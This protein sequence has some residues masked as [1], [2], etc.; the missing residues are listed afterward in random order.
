MGE[1]LGTLWQIVRVLLI[2]FNFLFFVL[3]LAFIGLGGYALDNYGAVFAFESGQAWSSAPSLLIALGVFIFLVSFLG[4]LGACLKHRV[5]LFVFGV[6][7]CFLLVLT[8]TG[9]ILGFQFKSKIESQLGDAMWK[10]IR[11]YNNTSGDKKAWDDL[12]EHWPKC[13]GVYH[14]F[15][16]TNMSLPIP[17]SC[18]IDGNPANPIQKQGCYNKTIGAITGHVAEAAGIATFVLFTELFGVVMAFGLG[19]QITKMSSGNYE[20][21]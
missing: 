9:T 13:C 19:R 10:S 18:H 16:W 17:D 7:M 21:V 11:K 2:V 6:I 15:D 5:L 14:S 4:F 1:A 12:Q 20:V 8:L 3:G